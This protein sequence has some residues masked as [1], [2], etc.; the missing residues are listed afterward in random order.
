MGIRKNIMQQLAY[1]EQRGG[2]KPL[3]QTSYVTYLHFSGRDGTL[4]SSEMWRL[5]DRRCWRRMKH[6]K[7]DVPAVAIQI[8]KLLRYV[9]PHNEGLKLMHNFKVIPGEKSLILTTYT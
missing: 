5:R 3:G 7:I 8:E 4:F 9:G 1:S 6:A 2:S